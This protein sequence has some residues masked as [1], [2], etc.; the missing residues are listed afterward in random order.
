ME[1]IPKR[2]RRRWKSFSCQTRAQPTR[3]ELMGT[4]EH[5]RKHALRVCG[6]ILILLVAYILSAG[7]AVYYV[8]R[9][10]TA[11]S[12]RI[13]TMIYRPFIGIPLFQKYTK[14]WAELAHNQPAKS[15]ASGSSG[16]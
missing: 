8:N 9:H 11:R 15:P 16:Q 6:G 12:V 10:L 2:R 14:F 5:P 13:I 7:P 4:D 1:R 3:F